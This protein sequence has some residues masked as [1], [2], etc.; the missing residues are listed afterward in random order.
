MLP[1][2][3]NRSDQRYISVRK[4]K[5]KKKDY[6]LIFA[7][8]DI[9]VHIEIWNSSNAIRIPNK[10]PKYISEKHCKLERQENGYTETRGLTP[11]FWRKANGMSLKL[12][13]P[14]KNKNI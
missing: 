6:R 14:R 10:K 11:K 8:P 3:L 5:R 9:L 7:M 4:R 13:T 1:K 2:F 12:Y